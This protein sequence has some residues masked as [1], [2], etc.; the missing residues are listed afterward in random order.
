ML[1]D[2]MDQSPGF[3]QLKVDKVKS[4][5]HCGYCN[6]PLWTGRAGDFYQVEIMPGLSCLSAP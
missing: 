4:H 2:D 6:A 3:R 5:A 1:D